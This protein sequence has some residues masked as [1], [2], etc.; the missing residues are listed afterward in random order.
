MDN[1]ILQLYSVRDYTEKDFIGTIK[2]IAEYGYKGVEFAGYGGLTASELKNLLNQTG[3]EATSTHIGIESLIN[4]TDAEIE[5]AKELDMKYIVCPY[6]DIKTEEDTLIIANELSKIIEKCRKNQIKLAYHNHSHE[7]VKDGNK[8][9]LD[10]LFENAPDL[11]FELD[12]FWTAYAGVDVIPYMNK[13]QNRVPLI[14]LKEISGDKTN[15][16]IGKGILDFRSIVKTAK[17]LGAKR[18][19]VEQEAYEVNSME[20]AKNN[21][22]Y[23]IKL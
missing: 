23:L 18:F 10:I 14:H 20:S 3:L 13:L 22:D 19:I 17:E 12:V 7:F 9:L 1:L 8:F 4:N 6:A 11:E 15:V 5:Y 16:D 2:R 21:I